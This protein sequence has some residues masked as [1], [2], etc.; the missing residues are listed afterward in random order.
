M[1]VYQETDTK[2]SAEDRDRP[3]MRK[4]TWRLENCDIT[5]R[6]IICKTVHISNE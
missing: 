5:Y 6:H 4:I 3:E 1:Y 2:F